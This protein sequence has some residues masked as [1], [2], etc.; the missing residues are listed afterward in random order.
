MKL[1][2]R[3]RFSR[4]NS[5]TP[6]EKLKVTRSLLK[7]VWKYARP[8]RWW[9]MGMLAITL[10]TTGLGLLTPLIL[11]DL[12][13]RTLPARDLNRLYLLMVGLIMIPLLTGG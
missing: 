7:R 12:I 6:D 13:D 8:Y 10:A 9:I 4:I 3:G 5:N 1:M 2:M 11:R